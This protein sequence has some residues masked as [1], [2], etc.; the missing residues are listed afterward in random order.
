MKLK[1]LILC[2][3]LLVLGGCSVGQNEFN[4]SL[5]SDNSVCAS[6]RTVYKATNG[7][8]VENNTITYVE[9]G[10]KKQITIDELNDLQHGGEMEDKTT[11]THNG[12]KQSVLTGDSRHVKTPY[13]YAY[14]GQALRSEVKVMRIWIAPWVDAQDTLHMSKVLFTDMET[15]KWSIVNNPKVGQSAELRLLRTAPS[16]IELANE[17]QRQQDAK[18]TQMQIGLQIPPED[19]RK[20]QQRFSSQT[21]TNGE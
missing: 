18:S 14:D 15:R 8:L 10:E 19:M 7:E 16:A 11:S 5:G 3:S 21:L 20:L 1:R 2:S 13:Q 12:S 6:S 9:D 4:C 17:E